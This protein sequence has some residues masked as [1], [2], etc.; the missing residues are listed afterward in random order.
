MITRRY[1][2]NP[3]TE[4]LDCSLL[5]SEKTA[6]LFKG[7]LRKENCYNPLIAHFFSNY[8]YSPDEVKT[9]VKGLN[10]TYFN[11]LLL[12]RRGIQKSELQLVIRGIE[13]LS[14]AF[15]KISLP[16]EDFLNSRGIFDSCAW[17]WRNK[18]GDSIQDLILWPT[19]DESIDGWTLFAP[20]T[21]KKIIVEAFGCL[22]DEH[23]EQMGVY[24]FKN[25]LAQIVQGKIQGD[26]FDNA[27]E[28]LNGK[29]MTGKDTGGVGADFKFERGIELC[30][31][32]K[33]PGPTD[34]AKLR[35]LDRFRKTLGRRDAGYFL[36]KKG[37][38]YVIPRDLFQ[39]A[40]E[41]FAGI[42]HKNS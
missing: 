14:H 4:Y 40:E 41:H 33:I 34:A 39:K 19:P 20:H 9:E 5:K 2:L 31:A 29:T 3:S 17:Y 35:T 15:E 1:S 24:G 8:D 10:A 30:V 6:G 38:G 32:L 25:P 23:T 7:V 21:P 13:R 18:K 22:L 12:I 36:R 11:S 26:T 28:F 37:K 16:F 27:K 42:C